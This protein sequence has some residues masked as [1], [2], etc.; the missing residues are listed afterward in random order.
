MKLRADRDSGDAFLQMKFI[1]MT[2]NEFRTIAKRYIPYEELAFDSFL[3]S[4]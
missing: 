1:S 4:N 3:A 2:R